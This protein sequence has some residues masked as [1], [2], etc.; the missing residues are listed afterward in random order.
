MN[1]HRFRL[2]MSWITMT[3][4][5]ALVAVPMLALGGCLIWEDRPRLRKQKVD[6][7]VPVVGIPPIMLDALNEHYLLIM[8]APNSGWALEIDRDERIAAGMRVFVT[9]RRPDPTFLYPQAIV[10]KRLLTQIRT[11]S[12]LEIYARLLDAHETTK[13]RGYGR[14]TPVEAFEE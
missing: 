12:P 13:G 1:A 11:D 6:M 4:L 7:N 8:Q 9:V 10:T 14:L 2:T 5:T 3:L